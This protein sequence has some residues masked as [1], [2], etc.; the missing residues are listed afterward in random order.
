MEEFAIDAVEK[1]LNA[2][3][4]IDILVNNAGAD[5]MF[6]SSASSYRD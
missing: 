2:F 6:A 5:H 3:G 1:T 4:K